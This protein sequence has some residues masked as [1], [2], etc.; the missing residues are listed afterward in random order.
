MNWFSS[1]KNHLALP[2]IIAFSLLPKLT[3]MLSNCPLHLSHLS[4][5]KVTHPASMVKR[6]SL[7]QLAIM[8]LQKVTTVE[9]KMEPELIQH[10]EVTT[11][12]LHTLTYFTVSCHP[13]QTDT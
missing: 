6:K 4:A 7:V 5:L 2:F 1:H 10:L 9:T 13:Y 11:L 12:Q 3:L 8:L